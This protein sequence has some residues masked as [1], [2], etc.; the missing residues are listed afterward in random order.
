MGKCRMPPNAADRRNH[1]VARQTIAMGAWACLVVADCARKE[2]PSVSVG[3]DR[4]ADAGE[5]E[6]LTGEGSRPVGPV[7]RYCHME[8]KQGPR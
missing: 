1:R 7:Q 5:R 4:T 8:E 2:P 3:A 6:T